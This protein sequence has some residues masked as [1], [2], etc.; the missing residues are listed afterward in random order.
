[1][2]ALK[3]TAYCKKFASTMSAAAELT[4]DFTEHF[5]REVGQTD[6]GSG[7]AHAR[8]GCLRGKELR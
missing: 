6:L 7:L 5:F 4:T 1:V 3:G 8:V 2:T